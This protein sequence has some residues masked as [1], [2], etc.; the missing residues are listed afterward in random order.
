MHC[1]GLKIAVPSN[2]YDAAGLLAAALEDRN[3]VLFIEH[4]KLYGTKSDLPDMDFAIPFGQAK[5][6]REGKDCT[7][8]ALSINVPEAVGAAERL[9]ADGVSV[10]VIDPRTLA[11]LDVATMVTSL[12]KTSRVAIVHDGYKT[13]GVA[14]EIAQRL[15]EE[16]FECLD[17]PIL[18]IAGWDV[19]VASETLHSAVVPTRD[20][21]ATA[22]ME[23]VRR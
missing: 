19:P 3:P 20:T 23:L 15:S 7:V 13:C 6:V 9:K 5:V 4:A 11:P 16:A 12:R 17:A 18:R 21:I 14:A 1:P 22:L 2:A 10:E 8:V